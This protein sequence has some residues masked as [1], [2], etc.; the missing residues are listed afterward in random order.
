MGRTNYANSKILCSK[1]SSAYCMEQGVAEHRDAE[2]E[3]EAYANLPSSSY[4]TYG[5]FK[6]GR[7]TNNAYS[8]SAEASCRLQTLPWWVK[9][10]Y[11]YSA[12]DFPTAYKD[13]SRN[14]V[15]EPSGCT[16]TSWRRIVRPEAPCRGVPE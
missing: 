11:R 1:V 14:V 10:R 12:L 6:K 9:A 13:I 16:R 15:D 7:R 2:G 5:C 4:G 3:G 8:S